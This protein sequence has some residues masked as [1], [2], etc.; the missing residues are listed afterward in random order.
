[1]QENYLSQQR[2]A[3]L[4]LHPI[5]QK[6]L[7]DK[8]FEYCTPIQALSLPITLQGKDVAG[9]AQTG[10]GKTIAFLT[11]TFHHLLTHQP[12]FATNQ[13]RALIL[14]PTRELAVQINNDAELLAKTSG[15][16]TA[17]AYGGDGYDKQLKAIEAG[18]DILIGTSSARVVARINAR[19]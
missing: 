13:P 2:F 1:M 17:L 6:A 10:T 19:G 9:Q 16:R 11:A 5:V 3:D 7:Q 15:L 8:G 18:V 14:A 12:D 4:P